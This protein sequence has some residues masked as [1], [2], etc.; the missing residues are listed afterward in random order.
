MCRG[1]RIVRK[2]RELEL[3]V[4]DKQVYNNIKIQ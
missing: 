4:N 3:L 1:S 2:Q